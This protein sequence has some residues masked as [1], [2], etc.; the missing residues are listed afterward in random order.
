MPLQ[1]NIINKLLPI[2]NLIRA[3][4]LSNAKLE[5]QRLHLV[6]TEEHLSQSKEIRH[7]IWDIYE[8]LVLG[9]TKYSSLNEI[10]NIF[11]NL[12]IKDR[13]Q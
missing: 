12:V 2:I 13:S 3:G 1:S 11:E 10:M 4:N 7:L 6:D 8:Y 9:N 5:F